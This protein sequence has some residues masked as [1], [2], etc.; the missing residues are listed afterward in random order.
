MT[1]LCLQWANVPQLALRPH[2]ETVAY[3]HS[4]GTRYPVIPDGQDKQASSSMNGP[5]RFL[6]TAKYGL[7]HDS[8]HR[9]H[10]KAN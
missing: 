2:Y 9:E 8:S 5:Q 1:E 6:V 4:G 7:Q 3:R 10:R